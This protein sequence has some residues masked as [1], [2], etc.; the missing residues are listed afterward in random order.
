M[1]KA[2]GYDGIEVPIFALDPG[3]YEVLAGSWWTSG[4]KRSR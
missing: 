4:W 3:P 2:T 1:L